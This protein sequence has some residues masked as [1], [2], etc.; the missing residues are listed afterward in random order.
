MICLICVVVAFALPLS[1]P[2]PHFPFSSPPP[3]SC[4]DM[5]TVELVQ[6]W[7]RT[8]RPGQ[9]CPGGGGGGGGGGG[10]RGEEAINVS[11]RKEPQ[12][13]KKKQHCATR[14]YILYPLS[15]YHCHLYLISITLYLKF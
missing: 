8:R 10:A 6:G 13:K 2:S 7:R 1:Y 14:T 15:F 4:Q 11:A 5:I 3:S 9:S 12:G